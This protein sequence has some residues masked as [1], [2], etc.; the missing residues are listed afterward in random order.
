MKLHGS[1]KNVLQL[2][3]YSNDRKVSKVNI[4]TEYAHAVK[5]L[6]CNVRIVLQRK[7]LILIYLYSKILI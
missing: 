6:P 7:K 4:E 5:V 3:E 1:A 2:N